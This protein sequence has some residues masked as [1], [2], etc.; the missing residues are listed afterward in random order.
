MKPL[1]GESI[2]YRDFP[3]HGFVSIDLVSYD[4]M[5]HVCRMHADLV[6]TSCEELDLDE[7]I[8]VIDIFETSVLGPSKFGIDRI[9]GR[10]LLV[11]LGIIPNI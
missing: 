1:P 2:S 6:R 4:R 7:R 8:S 9:F 5:T 11:I 10:H 3:I